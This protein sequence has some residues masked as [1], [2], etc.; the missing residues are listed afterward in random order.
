MEFYDLPYKDII[1]YLEWHDQP[2]PED[3]E[4]A[5]NAAYDLL[6]YTETDIPQSILNWYNSNIE[7]YDIDRL[8]VLPE[9]VYLLILRKLNCRDLLTLGKISLKTNNLI[10]NTDILKYGIKNSGYLFNLTNISSKRLNTLCKVLPNAKYG[11]VYITGK[12]DRGNIHYS[13]N[14]LDKLSDL[15]IVSS[16]AGQNHCLFLDVKGLVYAYG[17]NTSGESGFNPDT[18]YRLPVVSKIHGLPEIMDIA[19]GLGYS[20][21]V[22]IEGQV[23][24]SGYNGNGQLGLG[25][26]NTQRT[27]TIN[28]N[29][30]NIVSVSTGPDHSLFLTGEGEVYGCGRNTHHQLG[31]DGEISYL[32][33]LIPHL[34]KITT[35]Q[36]GQHHSLFL[37]SEG[38]VY[39]CGY[40][41]LGQLGFGKPG[42]ISHPTLIPQI[43]DIIFISTKLNHSLFVTK[44]GQV[45]GCGD[46]ARQQLGI[47]NQ[48]RIDVP[49]LIPSLPPDI[50]KA[51]AG[52]N[53]SFFLTKRGKLYRCGRS[54]ID[55]HK[56]ETPHLVTDM[57]DV[58]SVH[59]TA[60]YTLFLKF[61]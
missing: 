11:K 46:N 26:N 20:L 42:V 29:L 58:I 44:N 60:G 22:D 57:L 23:Y 34:V 19:A 54:D 36:T 1:H 2:I 7:Y 15:P 49:T 32:P 28:K 31:L 30:S 48:K 14:K 56:V 27:I 18:C 47:I 37:S 16:A 52:I 38:K 9:E 61:Y 24:V 55:V 41:E 43:S 21:F 33:Q 6:S 45:Y 3:Q 50:V 10:K 17:Y 59:D 5:Y 35:I 4:S 12:L 40:N 8:D 51:F 25:H 13:T 53:N 39:G